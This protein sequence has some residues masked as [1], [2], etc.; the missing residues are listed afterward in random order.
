MSKRDKAEFERARALGNK[1]T[2]DKSERE[3][4]KSKVRKVKRK[5]PQAH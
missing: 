1:R 3:I 4:P 5:L 2:K